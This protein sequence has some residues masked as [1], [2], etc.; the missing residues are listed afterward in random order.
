MTIIQ[1]IR[2]DYK[3]SLMRFFLHLRHL[4][5]PTLKRLA[6]H[7]EKKHE[8]LLLHTSKDYIHTFHG[9]FHHYLQNFT[10]NQLF[11]MEEFLRKPLGI[12]DKTLKLLD[13]ALTSNQELEKTMLIGC[14]H[15]QGGKIQSRQDLEKCDRIVS[16]IHWHQRLVHLGDFGNFQNDQ[17]INVGH[18]GSKMELIV[19]NHDR[20]WGEQHLLSQGFQKVHIK[21]IIL[22]NRII[23]SH[24]PLEHN[25]H[26][27]NIHAHDHG[28]GWHRHPVRCDLSSVNVGGLP[29]NLKQIIKRLMHQNLVQ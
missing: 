11:L 14:T 21:P 27:I 10:W 17:R 15:F 4:H 7:V 19:G 29:Q 9:Y 26:M 22:Q 23:L 6:Q 12:Q 25:T 20:D 1:H 13:D 18:I 8:T 3:D 24:E 16:N 28:D 2:N 5:Q